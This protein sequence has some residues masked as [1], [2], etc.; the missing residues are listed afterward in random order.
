MQSALD[1]AI[2]KAREAKAEHIHLIRLCVGDLAGVVP[3]ALEFAFEA[4]SPG[5]MAEGATFEIEKLPAI[6]HCKQCDMDFE[7]EGYVYA[8]PGCGA[9]SWDIRQGRDLYLSSMEVS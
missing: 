6:C 9:L 3:E 4:L 2:Q 8:C 1:I 7:P 5:T